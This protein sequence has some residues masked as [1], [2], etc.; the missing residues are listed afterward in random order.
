MEN[1][2]YSWI[3]FVS[4]QLQECKRISLYITFTLWDWGGRDEG[5]WWA[6]AE[7]KIQYC[8]WNKFCD[9]TFCLKCF[10]VVVVV[11]I[12]QWTTIIIIVITTSSLQE[13]LSTLT[14]TFSSL[15]YLNWIDFR[16][17]MIDCICEKMNHIRMC[18]TFGL[19]Y[20]KAYVMPGG[21]SRWSLHHYIEVS[22]IVLPSLAFSLLLLFTLRS[23][24]RLILFRA[25]HSLHY[26]LKHIA[27]LTRTKTCRVEMW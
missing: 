5:G 8:C 15:D 22:P 20:W 23:P 11:I 9:F 26:L 24:L 19:S 25:R 21:V 18:C 13:E 16:W 7:W 6:G 14:S 3:T 4:V 17:R 2:I 27:Q 1:C 10:V 12:T